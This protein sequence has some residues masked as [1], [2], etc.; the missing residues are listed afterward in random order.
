MPCSSS[1]YEWLALVTTDWLSARHR[2]GLH[3][4]HHVTQFIRCRR[5]AGLVN[6]IIIIICQCRADLYGR[7]RSHGGIGCQ[8]SGWCWRIKS[9]QVISC[10][11]IQI[12]LP[13]H[14]WFDQGHNTWGRSAGQDVALAVGTWCKGACP[15]EKPTSSLTPAAAGWTHPRVKKTKSWTTRKNM[16]L[17]WVTLLIFQIINS[18]FIN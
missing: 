7:R 4:I 15:F 16:Y 2:A 1:M 5:W 17:N 12:T 3:L 11:V 10:D 18:L 6:L 13:D 8:A 14:L 9:E